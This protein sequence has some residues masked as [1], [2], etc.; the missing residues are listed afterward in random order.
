[1]AWIWKD[2]VSPSSFHALSS[3]VLCY[4]KG[5]RIRGEQLL[6][7]TSC[8]IKPENMDIKVG[9]TLK[10]G[11]L[12]LLW[13]YPSPFEPPILLLQIDLSTSL[14]IDYEPRLGFDSYQRPSPSILY[15]LFLSEAPD[16]DQ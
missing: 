16:L 9:Y 8:T 11:I 1:M 4:N 5:K 15:A 12:G 13:L 3:T 6:K 14:C 2:L 10:D 7:H